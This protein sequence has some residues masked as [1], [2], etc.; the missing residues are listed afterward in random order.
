MVMPA[1]KKKKFAKEENT[2]GVILK[3]KGTRM[4]GDGED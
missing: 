2:K 3:Q 4:A 1:R